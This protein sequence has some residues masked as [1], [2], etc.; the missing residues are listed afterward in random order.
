M[1]DSVEH[2]VYCVHM[3]AF[4]ERN[5]FELNIVIR[6][7]ER[8]VTRGGSLEQVGVHEGQ[9]GIPAAPFSSR[10]SP[11]ISMDLSLLV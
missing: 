9:D 8:V 11:S 6:N 2:A 10:L 4:N 7:M 3:E 1:P 5:I